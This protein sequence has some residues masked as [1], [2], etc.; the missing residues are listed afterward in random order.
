MNKAFVFVFTF[1]FLAVLAQPVF[2][3]TYLNIY[4]D[5]SGNT[6]FLGETNETNLTLP[7]GVSL[8]D[9][10]ISG[11]T[12]K[13]TTKE[14]EV[15]RFSYSLTGAEIKVI[16]PEGSTIK[17]ITSGE[18][19]LERD[20][21]SVYFL[22]GATIFYTVPDVSSDSLIFDST[23]GILILVLVVIVSL[24]LLFYYRLKL[25]NKKN[26]RNVKKSGKKIDKLGIISQVLNPREKIII[27]KLK[28][29]GKVKMSHLRK[30][31]E[32]PKASF[33]RHIQELEKKK[34]ILRSGE[35]KN[36]FV[37]LT[38]KN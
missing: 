23:S 25:K 16:L 7:E 10:K 6:Q 4:V 30:L 20:R 27:D 26:S 19:F 22:N 31:S 11:T 32:I 21:I 35:G 9:G 3:Y 5:S 37:Q 36:K 1:V 24:G 8:Q 12:Q 17:R 38:K 15:W 34:L 14:Q 13:L 28:Q 18:I 2:G 33:S 29:T